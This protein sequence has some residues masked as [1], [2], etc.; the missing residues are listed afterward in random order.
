MAHEEAGRRS[1]GEQ[2]GQPK[3]IFLRTNLELARFR[4]PFP[5]FPAS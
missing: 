2:T 3:I 4:A 1:L 5:N